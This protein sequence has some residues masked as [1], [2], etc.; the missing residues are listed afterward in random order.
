MESR[1][2]NFQLQNDISKG[3][4]ESEVD[5]PMTQAIKESSL[6]ASS[7]GGGSGNRIS[8]CRIRFL[9]SNEK[10]VE[11]VREDGSK[12]LHTLHK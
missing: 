2:Q 7:V 12:E 9:Q 6:G 8:R 10:D 5:S 4:S 1:Q 3:I 11:L